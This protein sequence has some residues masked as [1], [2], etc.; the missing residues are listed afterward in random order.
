MKFLV[1]AWPGPML[2]PPGVMAEAFKA[3]KEWMAEQMKAGVVDCVFGFAAGGGCGIIN[4]SSGEELQALLVGS[5]LG[6]FSTFHLRPPGRF[7]LGDRSDH[8][9]AHGSCRSHGLSFEVRRAGDRCCSGWSTTTSPSRT[10][11]PGVERPTSSFGQPVAPCAPGP[12]PQPGRFHLGQAT[13]ARPAWPHG[14]RRP[15]PAVPV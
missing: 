2:S 1:L 5:P 13:G 3:S 4:A 14:P 12:G 10:T 9:A 15:R 8:Q 7:Q 6:P 11:S